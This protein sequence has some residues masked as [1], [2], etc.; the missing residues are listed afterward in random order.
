MEATSNSVRRL[1][2]CKAISG[3]FNDSLDELD[4]HSTGCFLMANAAATA[5]IS[6]PSQLPGGGRRVVVDTDVS[7]SLNR[8]ILL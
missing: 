8:L 6:T 5:A 4:V 2:L 1:A 7:A 3:I